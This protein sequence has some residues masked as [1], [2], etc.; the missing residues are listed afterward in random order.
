MNELSTEK[1]TGIDTM[2]SRLVKLAVNYLA[3]SFSKSVNN[4][5]ESLPQ[6]LP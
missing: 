4:N 3:R 6:L 2:L 5:I 1:S